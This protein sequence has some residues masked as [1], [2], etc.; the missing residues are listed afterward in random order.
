MYDANWEVSS[1]K[2]E[3]E[4][5]YRATSVDDAI[6]QTVNALRGDTGR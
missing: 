1:V 2:A 3:R 6:R 5:G 4:L